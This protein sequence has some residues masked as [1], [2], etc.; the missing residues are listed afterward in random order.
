MVAALS[1]PL[2]GAPSTSQTPAPA[3]QTQAK[4]PQA[5]Q[6]KPAADQKPKAA[7]ATSKTDAAAID[8]FK[9][10]VRAFV[11]LRTKVEQTLPPA[12][13]T[14]DPKK[15]ASQ[16]QTFAATLIEQRAGVVQGNVFVEQ[17]R[18]VLIRIIRDDFA[19]RPRADRRA[20]QE[21][22]PANVK[23]AVNTEYPPALPLVT[24]PASLL[25]ALPELPKDLEYRIVG[26]D[27]IL[28]DS[29]SGVVVDL[30]RNAFP[31]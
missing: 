14:K 17:C 15:L 20:L 7:A 25:K 5:K 24:V 22:L 16:Q 10:Q 29:R 3:G 21:D 26:R 31:A 13:E 28:F 12:A 27:L 23:V 9:E 2:L 19:R 6:T 30:I 11:A 4:Q 18:P 8:A 1:A